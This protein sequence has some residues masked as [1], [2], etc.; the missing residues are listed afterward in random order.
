MEKTFKF[1]EEFIKK[2]DEDSHQGYL[3]QVDIEY[4]K[5]LHDLHKDLRFL[6]E[7]MKIKKKACV[8]SV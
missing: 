6:L 8:Q 3:L 4:S 5:K 2:H 1:N 7:R